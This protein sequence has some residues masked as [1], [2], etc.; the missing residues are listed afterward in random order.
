MRIGSHPAASI[1]VQNS[2]VATR[3][4]RKMRRTCNCSFRIPDAQVANSPGSLHVDGDDASEIR[5]I[6]KPIPSPQPAIA[7]HGRGPACAPDRPT[8]VSSPLPAWQWQ[9]Y[10]RIGPR[11]VPDEF[12]TRDV[13]SPASSIEPAVANTTTAATTTPLPLHHCQQYQSSWPPRRGR[14]RRSLKPG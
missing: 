2:T 6:L 3:P 11:R 5:T 1:R 10:P 7:A 9:Y 12:P 14:R 13:L 8:S 4:H